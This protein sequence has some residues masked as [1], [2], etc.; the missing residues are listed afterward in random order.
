MICL[1]SFA[2]DC[3]SDIIGLVLEKVNLYCSCKTTKNSGVLLSALDSP[4]VFLF[5]KHR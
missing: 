2:E 1:V 3:R 4:E 5:G